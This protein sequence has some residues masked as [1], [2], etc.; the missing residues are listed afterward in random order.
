MV[1]ILKCEHKECGSKEKV[2]LEF[3]VKENLQGLK[4]HPYCIRC[5]M[6]RNVGSDKA[7][8]SGYYINVLSDMEKHLKIPGSNVRMRLVA[9]ELGKI[10]DFDDVYSMSKY[11]QDR[12]FT[13]I[14]KKYYQIPESVIQSYL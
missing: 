8:G 5:G 3:Q 9:K 11:I 14:V 4:L 13:N 7:K 6:V 1:Y 10:E 2:W 12:T